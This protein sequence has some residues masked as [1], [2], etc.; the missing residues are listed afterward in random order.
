MLVLRLLQWLRAIEWHRGPGE[1][2]CKS[3]SFMVFIREARC[4]RGLPVRCWDLTLVALMPLEYQRA[5]GR[6]PQGTVL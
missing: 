3:V 2:R 5:E 4:F 6:Q 1:R